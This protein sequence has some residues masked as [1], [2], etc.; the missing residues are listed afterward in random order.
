MRLARARFARGDVEAAERLFARAL[1]LEPGQTE[2]LA[3]LAQLLEQRGRLAAAIEVL[4]AGARSGGDQVDI[5]ARLSRLSRTL[6]D[7][8]GASRWLERARALFPQNAAVQVESAALAADSGREAEVDELLSGPLE[9]SG[10]L[11]TARTQWLSATGRLAEAEDCLRS[12][13]AS[14]P[15]DARALHALSMLPGAEM[16]TDNEET[17]HDIL[18]GQPD[19]RVAIQALLALARSAERTG[20]YEAAFRYFCAANRRQKAGVS[21]QAEDY[22][23]MFRRHGAWQ[24][25]TTLECLEPVVSGEIRPIWVIGMP[26][27]GTTLVEQM[28]DAHPQIRGLGE[29]EYVRVLVEALEQASGKPF[30]AGLSSETAPTLRQAASTYLARLSQRARGASLVVDKLPHNFLRVGVLHRLFPTG[31][32]VHCR[33]EP[34][35]NCWSI[36]THEFTDS[37]AYATDLEELGRYYRLYRDLMDQW[38][39]LVGD[40]LIEIRLEALVRQPRSA[41]TPILAAAGLDWHEGCAQ[42]HLNPRPVFTP[43]AVAIRQQHRKALRSRHL[44]YLPWLGPLQAGLG[45]G[46]AGS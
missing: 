29:I 35:A 7:L 44:D 34:V 9:D 36:F 10:M 43:S 18:R 19:H 15:R 25:P 40:R 23:A 33:R 11:L 30:P 32:F 22:P 3:G 5:L 1:E 26:R 13:L 24:D 12:Q 28:L 31:I 39:L 21:G 4:A 46:D 2:A 6:G 38:R 17:L 8:E 42:P 20:H 45:S 41:L 14:N 27:S 37:H 16:T